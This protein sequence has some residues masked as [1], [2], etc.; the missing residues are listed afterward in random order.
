MWVILLLLV[1]FVISTEWRT[2]ALTVV[3]IITLVLA[4][5]SVICSA[6]LRTDD[7]FS[8]VNCLQATFR[9]QNKGTNV[10]LMLST[11]AL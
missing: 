3:E 1:L 10:L 7:S 11:G 4:K 2:A 5:S 9:K 8:N 6:L